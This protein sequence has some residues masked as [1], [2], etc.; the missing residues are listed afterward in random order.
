MGLRSKQQFPIQILVRGVVKDVQ[1]KKIL[2]LK[3]HV[4]ALT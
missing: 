3:S 1:F 2:D 4:R